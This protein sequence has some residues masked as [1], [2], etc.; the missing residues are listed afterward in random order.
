MSPLEIRST[1]SAETLQRADDRVQRGVDALDN[2]AV[3]ALVLAGVGAC[4]QL[5]FYRSLDSTPVS[6][7]R[8]LMASMQVFRLFLISLKSPL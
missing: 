5:A 3:V 7:T 8:A 6:A 1:Y 2:F 4:G